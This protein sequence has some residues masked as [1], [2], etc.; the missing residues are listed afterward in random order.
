MNGTQKYRLTNWT[1]AALISFIISALFGVIMRW[2][3]VAD[4]PDW[5]VFKNMRHTHSHVAMLGWLYSGLYIFIVHTFK[6][7]THKYGSLFWWTQLSV[8]GM[9]VSFPLQGYGAVSI[10]FSSFHIIL[11][12][13]FIL[14]V[15]Q[16]LKKN[17]GSEQK[18]SVTFLKTSLIF[19]F[20]STIGAWS[21]GP[22]LLSSAGKSS[23]YYGAIQFFL[24]FQFNGW[25]IFAMIAIFLQL[26]HDKG[27]ILPGKNIDRFYFLL[28]ISCILT[29]ALAVTWSTPDKFIFWINSLGVIIQLCAL[30]YLL[31]IIIPVKKPIKLK[32]NAFS[33][34][35][36][37]LAFLGLVLKIV[38]QTSVAVPYIATI[39]YTMRNFVIGFIHL[40]MLG[41]ISLFLFG[42]INESMVKTNKKIKVGINILLAGFILS[43]LLLFIQGVMLWMTKGFIPYYYEILL[44]ASIL[45]PLGVIIYYTGFKS[46]E[47]TSPFISTP[48]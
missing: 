46:S 39:S 42:M 21:L 27:V 9:L 15:F 48:K 11:S 35:L 28:S 13:V 2:A 26:M 6:L 30:L 4:L 7:N 44:F 29:F 31:K 23:L 38:V 41:S 45:M 19:L 18:P 33:F 3:F 47:K 36:L 22:I 24:H 20:I 1:R 25:F 12:Y 40:L 8:L 16:D 32:L 5:V 43:E 17:K 37:G 10:T 34:F 14:F